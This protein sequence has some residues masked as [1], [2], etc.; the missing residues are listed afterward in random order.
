MVILVIL[1]ILP[2]G[3]LSPTTILLLKKKRKE[4]ERNMKT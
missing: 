2:P 3:V 1:G 4:K